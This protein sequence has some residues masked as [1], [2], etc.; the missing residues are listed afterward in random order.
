M[1]IFE[2]KRNM[3][4]GVGDKNSLISVAIEQKGERRGGKSFVMCDT[5]GEL[6]RDRSPRNRTPVEGSSLS[7]GG[8]N[9]FEMSGKKSEPASVP[10][11]REGRGKRKRKLRKESLAEKN[12]LQE[13]RTI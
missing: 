7:Q 9:L 8:T 4:A 3:P 13:S 10:L 6:I 5:E 1:F 12:C 11:V 2:E